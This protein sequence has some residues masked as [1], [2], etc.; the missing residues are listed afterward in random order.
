MSVNNNPF[1]KQRT[2]A[3]DGI[4]M[5]DSERAIR[6]DYLDMYM[7]MT[8][9]EGYDSLDLRTK[10]RLSLLFRQTITLVE[11]ATLEKNFE[12]S[13]T[14]MSDDDSRLNYSRLRVR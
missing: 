11:A 6:N 1:T 8:T 3:L 7:Y 14:Q 13:A 5:S 4:L 9:S 2:D 10:E 12:V